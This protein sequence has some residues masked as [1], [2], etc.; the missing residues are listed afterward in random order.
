L[1]QFLQ[2]TTRRLPRHYLKHLLSDLP[3]LGRLGVCCL[4][5]LRLTALSETDGKETKEVAVRRLDVNVGFD[6]CLPLANERTKF[7]GCKVHAVEICQAIL[8]LHLINS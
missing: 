3:Y 7:V 6:E 2:V 5:D 1:H 8:A 4:S